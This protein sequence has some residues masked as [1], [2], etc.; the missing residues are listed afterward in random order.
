M[1]EY[2]EYIEKTL[3]VNASVSLYTHLDALPLY[4]RNA[5]DLSILTIQNVQCLLARPKEPANLTTLRKQCGQMKNLTGIDCVLCLEGIRIYTKEKM[6]AEGIP[7]IIA[8]Q[9]IY[10]PFLGIVLSKNGI[11]EIP[12]VEQLSFSTQKLLLTAIYKGW[13]QVT[14]TEAAK[15]LGTSKMTVTR[16][17]D[18]LQSLGLTIVKSEGKMRRFIWKG[19][20]RA[21][22][23][24]VRPFLRNS[25]SLQYR[26]AEIIELDSKK[27]SGLSAICHYSMLADNSY[28]VYAISKDAAK[29]LEPRKLPLAPEDESPAMII[30]VIKCDL[31]YS[32]STA[33]DPLTAILSLKDEEMEDPRVEAAVEEILEDCLYD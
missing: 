7:F 18:E 24:T 19:G 1:I 5:Y 2:I 12:R 10:M 28:P 6:L 22:W 30:Q 21:L 20:Q 15:A 9:Q 13:V 27:L 33:I 16:C 31:E 8:D 29:R 14:L 4:L 26:L 3:H 11:R 23:E 25:V 17:F 32:D